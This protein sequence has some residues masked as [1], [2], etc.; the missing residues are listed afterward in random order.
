M[1]ISK[2]QQNAKI[3]FLWDYKTQQHKLIIP[4]V[5]FIETKL[6]KNP[7]CTTGVCDLKIIKN[8][9]M[10]ISVVGLQCQR[11]IKC[12]QMAHSAAYSKSHFLY[13]NSLTVCRMPFGGGGTLRNGQKMG[14]APRQRALS[15]CP[16]IAAV[17]GEEPNCSDPPTTLS[18]RSHCMQLLSLLKAQ[19]QTQR[20]SF[21]ICRRN[22]AEYCSTSQ[23]HINRWLPE[24]LPPMA[25]LL[26]KLYV[27][28]RGAS[29]VTEWHFIHIH[30]SKDYDRIP[31]TTWSSHVTQ[32]STCL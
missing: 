3:T 12:S 29:R 15:N 32:S 14:P 18:T 13:W 5:R 28:K 9:K 8:H 23:S 26:E 6:F 30:F 22:S 25:G 10:M 7:L 2:F 24:T 20:S 27:Q 11:T 1:T 16:C 19:D 17:F 4:S 21:Y 31:G